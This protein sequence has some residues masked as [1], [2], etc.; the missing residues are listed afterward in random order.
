M[1]WNP[2]RD[3][4]S[5]F[6]SKQWQA[7]KALTL[8]LQRTMPLGGLHY[9]FECPAEYPT[10]LCSIFD[11][12]CKKILNGLLRINNKQILTDRQRST[13]GITRKKI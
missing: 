2:G 13:L 9:G 3:E 7:E 12:V 8:D 1:E 6:S 11:I 4:L 5:G 10:L